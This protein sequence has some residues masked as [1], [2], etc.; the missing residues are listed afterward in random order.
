MASVC[1]RVASSLLQDA[2]EK[3]CAS[4]QT[5]TRGAF[6]GACTLFINTIQTSQRLQ[7]QDKMIW[8]KILFTPTEYLDVFIYLFILGLVGFYSLCLVLG[9]FMDYFSMHFR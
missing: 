7:G 1:A 2:S 5:L 8:E 3:L 6:T 9:D 4:C